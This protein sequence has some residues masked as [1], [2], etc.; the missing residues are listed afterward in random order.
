MFEK[1]SK[2]CGI[3]SGLCSA[4]VHVGLTIF[5][6]WVALLLPD[7]RIL[8]SD[9]KA[10]VSIDNNKPGV[11]S[12]SYEVDFSGLIKQIKLSSTVD[13]A[14]CASYTQGVSCDFIPN[15]KMRCQDSKAISCQ[16]SNQEPARDDD[17]GSDDK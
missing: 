7:I 6:V 8:D 1:Y 9:F 16:D 3:K 17:S 4:L 2:R 11:K 10:C 12:R 14:G 13:L 15:A 5:G